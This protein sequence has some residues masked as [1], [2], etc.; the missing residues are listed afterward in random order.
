MTKPAIGSHNK[1]RII[2]VIGASG[3]GKGAWIKTELLPNRKG[4]AVVWS[5][6]EE[7]DGYAKLLGVKE[8]R[9]IGAVIEGWR[10]GRDVVYVPPLNAKLIVDRFDLFCRAVW[11]MPGANV[12]VE[13]L[14]RVTS[15]S[16]APGSWQ[17]LSTAGRH[18]GITLMGTAQRPAQIDKDFLANC[19]E[20]RCYRLNYDPDA[21]SVA[22]VLRVDWPQ[23]LDLD[24]G[25]Y[26]HRDIRARSTVS[27]VL[28]CMSGRKTPARSAPIKKIG[29]IRPRSSAKNG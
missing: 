14:S 12:L 3:T 13:E 10:A 20:V 8:T 1:A 7:T 9:E 6:L 16:W 15:P 22:A 18:R 2:G 28:A 23:L 26:L 27:G 4:P 5:V 25:H 11:H 24:D 21:K 19:T 29:L 17:N